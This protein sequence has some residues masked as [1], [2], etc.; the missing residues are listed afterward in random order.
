MS[1]QARAVEGVQLNRIAAGETHAPV[2][3]FLAV[4]YRKQPAVKI[5]TST[6]LKVRVKGVSYGATL[7]DVLLVIPGGHN[8]ETAYHRRFAEY[9]LEGEL[10]R[11][12]GDLKAFVGAAGEPLPLEPNPE[13]VN[14]PIVAGWNVEGMGL[15]DIVA[16]GLVSATVKA[17]RMDRHRSDLGELPDDLKFPEP[18]GLD[19]QKELFDIA[20]IQAFDELRRGTNYRS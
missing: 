13:P 10:F 1:S 8:V 18:V 11:L 3:Y 14:K 2:V 7:R 6:R 15:S 17:L 12:E 19:G 20:A 9:Q 16:A 5:G 4:H